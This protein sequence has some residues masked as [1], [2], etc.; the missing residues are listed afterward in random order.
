MKQHMAYCSSQ[1]SPGS[2][3]ASLQ[4]L[5]WCDPA[6]MISPRLVRVCSCT[7]DESSTLRDA[8]SRTSIL[9]VVLVSRLRGVEH[10]IRPNADTGSRSDLRPEPPEEL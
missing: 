3:W 9:A 4:I 10:A 2:V 8:V 5:E 6:S 1:G 7:N